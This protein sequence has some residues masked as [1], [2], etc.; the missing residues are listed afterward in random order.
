MVITTPID[1]GAAPLH[2]GQGRA[3]MD[4]VWNAPVHIPLGMTPCRRRLQLLAWVPA[5]TALALAH[6]LAVAAIAVVL[7]EMGWQRRAR[8]ARAACLDAASCWWLLYAD[9]GR[10]PA[11]LLPG[12]L[13]HPW[14]TVLTLRARGRRC[15]VV[16]LPD[17]IAAEDFRR[18]RARLLLAA[19]AA[20]AGET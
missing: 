8:R 18:L 5:L 7:L 16:L 9:G 12:A 17:T 15:R 14:L 6:P 19:T 11:E 2:D 10:V 1:A 3:G 20:T 4:G 13:V